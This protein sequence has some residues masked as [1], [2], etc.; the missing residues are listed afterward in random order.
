MG[1]DKQDIIV[2][3]SKCHYGAKHD[4]PLLRIAFF[5][6]NGSEAKEFKENKYETS[7][8]C[9]FQEEILRVYCRDPN[10][11]DVA[12]DAFARWARQHEAPSPM[13]TFSQEKL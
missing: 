10:K 8:P 6:K 3:I 2:K 4:N 1:L 11:L 5:E 13:L 7:L 9:S 12:R